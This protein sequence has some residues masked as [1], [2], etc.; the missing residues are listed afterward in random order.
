M[1]VGY[2][3]EEFE[4]E[5]VY[6]KFDLSVVPEGSVL[7][8]KLWLNHKYS[9]SGG[10]PDYIPCN[11]T[12]MAYAVDDDSWRE[13]T[14]TWDIAEADYP[15]VG[16]NLDTVKILN[17]D[18]EMYQSWDV[19]SYVADEVAGDKI[20]SIC[21]KSTAEDIPG[22]DCAV[23][24]YTENA[25]EDQPRPYLEV[26]YAGVG[27]EI[28]PCEKKGSRGEDVTF[29][30][31]VRNET[32]A[33]DTFDFD[34]DSEWEAD[35]PS[36]T[37]LISK[38]SSEDVTLTVTIPDDAALGG[39]DEITVTARAHTNPAIYNFD[40]CFAG[41]PPIYPSDDAGVNS[42]DPSSNFG[43]KSDIHVGT[44]IDN[45]FFEP[46]DWRGYFRFDLSENIPD[47]MA[48]DSAYLSLFTHYGGENGAQEGVEETW[49]WYGDEDVPIAAYKVEDDG[50][51]EGGINWNN[52]QEMG[53]ALF[54][55]YIIPPEDDQRYEWDITS[56][57]QEEWAGDGVVSIGLKSE[58]EGQN[59]F[60]PF[61]SKETKYVRC[62]YETDQRP[63]L[64]VSYS[65]A[66]HDVNVSISP[67]S[68][69]GGAGGTLSY[70]VTV[71]NIGS[72]TDTYTLSKSDTAGWA[73]SL[74]SSVGPLAPNED[75]E[76]TLE[77]TI[78]S[79][80]GD[81][82]STTVTVTATCQADPS[83]DDS[84]TCTATARAGPNV[85]V[86]I[87]PG[88]Q[89]G[90]PGDPLSYTVTVTNTGTVTDTYDLET[91]GGAGWSPSL[92]SDTVGPLDPT[93]HE[94]VTLE[95]T[96]PSDAE[97]GDSTMVTVTATSQENSEVS[98][99]GS[100]TAGSEVVENMGVQ[101]TIDQATKSGAPGEDLNFFVTITNTGT[102]TDTYSLTA[103]DTEDWGT[104]LSVFETT[105]DGGKSRPN[106]K[107][108]VMIPD[109]ATEGDS[110]MVTVEAE[111]TYSEDSA[112]CTAEVEAAGEFPLIPVVGA[113]VVVVVIV[114]VILVIRH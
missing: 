2:D 14:L 109:D 1:Y 67:S 73:L 4:S 8:A 86:S 102:E 58:V 90:G 29:T 82:D 88:S 21:L 65:S 27:V 42:F 18:T 63:Y 30:V 33:P 50:W 53:D 6:L 23:W 87:S 113:V 54:T 91:S 39:E 59:K 110:T 28:E 48:I 12:V 46:E 107:L 56:Y 51:T 105:L 64:I 34:V 84:D 69:S 24:F 26:E 111:G 114:G 85:D 31:T 38:G 89:S 3:K 62:D 71:K 55:G 101:V 97:D 57:V 11:L 104:T 7:D 16:D 47:G 10:G 41:V 72:F 40:S 75:D 106:I 49:Q 79:D 100:C 76:V 5:R 35:I 80:A 36:S 20:V 43:S 52:K 78:P 70:T 74:T 77:V 98:D 15:P 45:V 83:V 61:V 99:S 95:V 66:A 17:T 108:T 112:T 44:R 93:E 68:Q 103:S 32:T 22:A 37:G 19:T 94:D 60:V 13:S 9:P 81:G 92:S 96:V 25:Y